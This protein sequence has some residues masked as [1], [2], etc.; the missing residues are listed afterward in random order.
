[1][2]I[3]KDGITGVNIKVAVK[4]EAEV[5]HHHGKEIKVIRDH[6]IG[7]NLRIKSLIHRLGMIIGM[8]R[9]LI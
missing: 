1:M 2:T 8:L 9:K 4:G 7:N 6:L 3:S 5:D